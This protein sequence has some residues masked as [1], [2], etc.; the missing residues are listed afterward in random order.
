MPHRVPV[1]C[2][3]LRGLLDVATFT[4]QPTGDAELEAGGPVSPVEFERLG[5][6]AHC[7]RWRSSI[8]VP[9]AS[10]GTGSCGT[11]KGSSSI[12]LGDWALINH[13]QQPPASKG[14]RP[15]EDDGGPEAS[16]G[17]SGCKRA[18]SALRRQLTLALP[19][20][21]VLA[22]LG[23]PPGGDGGVD[24]QQAQQQALYGAAATHVNCQ[25][26]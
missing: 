5:G 21:P 16:L 20:A 13:V 3:E 23:S 2:G 26:V 10:P 25:S 17:D 22:P 7:K 14:S 18:M 4:I 15:R 8:R 12:S 24:A 11:Q 6:R 9:A 1:V 19:A